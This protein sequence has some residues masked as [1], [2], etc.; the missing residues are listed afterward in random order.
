MKRGG[1]GGCRGFEIRGKRQEWG[2][3]GMMVKGRPERRRGR[4]LEGAAYPGENQ[5]GKRSWN[6]GGLKRLFSD[7]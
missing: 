5:N 2:L 1:M 6:G 7:G 3:T 4:E